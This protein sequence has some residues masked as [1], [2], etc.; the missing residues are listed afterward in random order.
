[1]SLASPS[2]APYDPLSAPRAAF[3]S[4]TGR[5]APIDFSAGSYGDGPR[6][7]GQHSA[8]DDADE[9]DWRRELDVLDGEFMT[10][11]PPRMQDC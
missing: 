1:M 10:G 11:E 7:N 2:S 6:T 8:Y 5:Q 4:H 9:S 3:T